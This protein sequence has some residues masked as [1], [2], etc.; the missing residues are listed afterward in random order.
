MH[1][2]SRDIKVYVQLEYDNMHDVII[3]ISTIN[4]TL[5][6]VYLASGEDVKDS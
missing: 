5:P 2:L 1:T 6:R 4:H 3:I